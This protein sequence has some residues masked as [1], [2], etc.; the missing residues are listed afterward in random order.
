M[1][2]IKGYEGLYAITED[3]QVYS[4]RRKIY[5]K[6]RFSKSTGY[7]RVNLSKDGKFK[8]CDIHRLVAQTYIPNPDGLPLVDHINR[9]K[10]DNRV[11]NLRWVSAKQN[12]RNMD[13][14]RAVYNETTD[15][16]F[17]SI[18]EAAEVY[19]HLSTNERVAQTL[20]C[21][22]CTGVSQSALGMRWRYVEKEQNQ[23]H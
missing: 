14:N 15:E 7:A 18:A 3:G 23:V 21:K 22:N 4:I 16:T 6:Q 11:E 10:R 1:K 2:E 8:T 13:V 5:L 17:Q 12:S 20:I 9:N 19:A